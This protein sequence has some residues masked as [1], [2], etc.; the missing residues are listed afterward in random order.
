MEQKNIQEIINRFPEPFKSATKLNSFSFDY[1]LNPGKDDHDF[2]KSQGYELFMGGDSAFYVRGL[3]NL[4]ATSY[5][6]WGTV[7]SDNFDEETIQGYCKS[8]YEFCRMYD[9]GIIR[10]LRITIYID[11]IHYTY[12]DNIK[13]WQRYVNKTWEECENPLNAIEEH[14]TE[15]NDYKKMMETQYSYLDKI[16]IEKYMKNC[17]SSRISDLIYAIE[18][19]YDDTEL[20]DNDFLEGFIFNYCNEEEFV[21]YL[22]RRFGERIYISEVS[23]YTF[24]LN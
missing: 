8:F 10:L 11:S 9:E 21:E 5:G 18:R 3:S 20:T 24:G 1:K 13:S 4:N 14:K 17:T 16:D 22:T 19:D 6:D 12:N 7:Y 15:N 2:L 23:Y